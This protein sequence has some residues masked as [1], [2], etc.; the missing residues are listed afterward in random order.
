MS[1]R[2]SFFGCQDGRVDGGVGFAVDEDWR[3]DGEFSRRWDREGAFVA[4][5]Q[6]E[7]GDTWWDLKVGELISAV[8]ILS[9]NSNPRSRMATHLRPPILRMLLHLVPHQ[10]LV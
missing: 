3:D 4:A 10:P 5:E 8:K 9:L 6:G 7:W 2:S 1:N